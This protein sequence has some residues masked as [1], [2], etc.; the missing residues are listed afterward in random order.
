[1]FKYNF[2]IQLSDEERIK[3]LGDHVLVRVGTGLSKLRENLS[4]PTLQSTW[5]AVA[6]SSQLAKNTTRQFSKESTV[7]QMQ[8]FGE[9]LILYRSSN[10]KVIAAQDR[11]PHRSAPLSMG[12]VKNGS[13]T[14]RYHDWSF[15]NNG[16]AS[17]IPNASKDMMKNISLFTY[18]CVEKDEII[19]VYYSSND[20]YSYN[21]NNKDINIKPDES[22]ILR[23]A[24]CKDYTC[25]RNNSNMKQDRSNYNDKSDDSD[26]ENIVTAY[27]KYG[28]IVDTIGDL[29]GNWLHH[30]ENLLDFGHVYFIHKSLIPFRFFNYNKD[31]PW[32]IEVYKDNRGYLFKSKNS[33]NKV[34]F[35]RF[36]PPNMWMSSPRGTNMMQIAY[37]VPVNKNHTRMLFRTYSKVFDRLN[38]VPVLNIFLKM[39]NWDILR[40]DNML[41]AGQSMR[42]DYLD[43]P[44]V[45][46]SRSEDGYIKYLYEWSTTAINND[47]NKSKCKSIWFRG[48][49]ASNYGAC[50]YYS[51]K[52]VTNGACKNRNK[53]NERQNSS[54][55]ENENVDDIED[56]M[57]NVSLIE[58]PFGKY[59]SQAMIKSY[60]PS[61]NTMYQ[62]LKWQKKIFCFVFIC[63][64]AIS[65]AGIVRCMFLNETS[66]NEL[67][68]GL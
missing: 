56:I 5:Y 31:S 11:C 29:D 68:T 7:L 51:T 17:D 34:S 10:N 28:G 58:T 52:N 61:N 3:K 39:N 65:V 35:A 4:N 14:C 13:L 45:L 48:W 20:N 23:P 9:P 63:V 55:N 32:D 22:E 36:D 50:K 16:S 47:V 1:M 59:S 44:I 37:I 25:S 43:A 33:N 49:N 30:L 42:V 8:L 57:S 41:I 40:Q 66:W 6:F 24:W 60:P 2:T 54:G 53:I 19:F 67:K 46:N 12:T 15:N 26:E 64:I 18:P 62:Q 27:D 38:R 21:E